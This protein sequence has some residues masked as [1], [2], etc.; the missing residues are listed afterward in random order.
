[1]M[2]RYI[3]SSVIIFFLLV[4]SVIPNE[5]NGQSLP[6][7]SA[8]TSL[9]TS[10]TSQSTAQTPTQTPTNPF[11][12]TPLPAVTGPEN[13]IIET[14][15]LTASRPAAQ[16]DDSIIFSVTIQNRA[17]Y[18]KDIQTLCFESTDGNFGCVWGINLAPGQTTT[19]QNVGTWTQGGVKNVWITL[20]CFLCFPTQIRNI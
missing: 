16:V 2:R 11:A 18:N 12:F 14:Q 10:T 20:I 4:L 9:S 8:Q 13:D 6:P 1:M 7:T 5:A 3:P 17:V 15:P 19:I